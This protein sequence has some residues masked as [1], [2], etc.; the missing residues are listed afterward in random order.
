MEGKFFFEH[1]LIWVMLLLWQIHGYKSCILKERK[2]LLELKDYL[3]SKSSESLV[4]SVLK[5]RPEEPDLEYGE[6]IPVLSNYETWTN[7]K[8]R[9]CCRWNGIKCNRTSGRV[10]GP[11]V[12][13]VYFREPNSLL[14]LSFLRIPLMRFKVW[15]YPGKDTSSHIVA[16]LMMLKVFQAFTFFSLPVSGNVTSNNL[17][18]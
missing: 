6:A 9:D 4:G 14:N 18:C 11:S 12:G 5:A 16:S 7:D 10:I 17:E 8:K 2:A 15:T 1:Y 3:I 13:S